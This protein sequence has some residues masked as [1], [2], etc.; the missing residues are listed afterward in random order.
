MARCVLWAPLEIYGIRVISHACLSVVLP[1]PPLWI[2]G[3][4]DV[5]RVLTL[6]VE[7]A[8]E[9]AEVRLLRHDPSSSD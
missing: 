3:V 6:R 1:N 2:H 5:G 9:V 7:R 8:E 4:S